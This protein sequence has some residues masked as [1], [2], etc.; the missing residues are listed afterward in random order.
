MRMAV[1]QP[2]FGGRRHIGELVPVARPIA[3]FFGQC[4][5]SGEVAHG[6]A[7]LRGRHRCLESPFQHGNSSR[8]S[9]VQ[10]RRALVDLYM[11]MWLGKKEE[12]LDLSIAKRLGSCCCYS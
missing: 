8:N 11:P 12:T 9:V 7:L 6:D 10:K 3:V 4:R 5:E 1:E 2:A